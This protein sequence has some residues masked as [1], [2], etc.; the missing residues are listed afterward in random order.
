MIFLR[1]GAFIVLSLEK[2]DF[3]AQAHPRKRRVTFN[4][5]DRKNSRSQATIYVIRY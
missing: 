2:H 4:P 3:L 5:K 1:V